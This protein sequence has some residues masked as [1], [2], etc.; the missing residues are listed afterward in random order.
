VSLFALFGKETTMSKIG[1]KPID[2]NDTKVEVVGQEIRYKGKISSGTYKLPEFLK[3]EVDGKQLRLTMSQDRENK[4]FWGLH[5]ALLA[6][7]LN[8]S[9]QLF[10]KKLQIIGL[11]YK[12]ELTSGKVKL[13]LGYSHKIEKILPKEVTL[14]IDKSGQLLTFKSHDKEMLGQVCADIRSLRPPEPYKGTG[15]KLEN[16]VIFR[17]AG[18]TKAA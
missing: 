10:E 8:G 15:I 12:A 7:K 2:L 18:K 5:R 1:R 11:G 6:N 14:E 9:N 16:E 17:K 13:S 4:K 3:A